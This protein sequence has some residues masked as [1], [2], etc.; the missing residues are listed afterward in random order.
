MPDTETHN[1]ITE[2]SHCTRCGR[3]LKNPKYR[4]TGIGPVCQRKIDRLAAETVQ[5]NDSHTGTPVDPK[6]G[7]PPMTLKVRE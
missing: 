1:V 2:Y 6:L 5:W 3:V 4:L 7:M